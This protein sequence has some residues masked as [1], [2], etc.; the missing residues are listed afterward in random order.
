[1]GQRNVAQ[2]KPWIGDPPRSEA[3]D[4]PGY[5]QIAHERVDMVQL[6]IA[7]VVLLPFWW[8]VFAGLDQLINGSSGFNVTIGF[9]EVIFGAFIAL[10][11]VPVVHELAHG[12]TAQA[13]GAQ[14]SYGIGPGYAYTT[15][16]EPMGR[17]AYLGVG[18][19]PLTLIS[20]VGA[21]LMFLVP[22]LSG[23]IILT[24][25]V[26]AAGAV[27]DLWMAQTILRL[28]RRAIF[29]DLADGFAAYVPD[30]GPNRQREASAP[31]VQG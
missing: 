14:P 10:I 29:Y 18:L 24:C 31:V 20:L 9:W 22:S 17:W 15:F 28:P 12:L 6:S 30:T 16:R 11:F 8:F 1:M 13:L 27:G 5:I 4:E 23:W 19:A 7:G 25:I 3:P 26:N 21:L 2:I